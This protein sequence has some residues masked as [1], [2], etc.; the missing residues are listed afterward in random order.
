[1]D[2]TNIIIVCIIT[3]N[4]LI[5]W[6]IMSSSLVIGAGP[7]ADPLVVCLRGIRAIFPSLRPG[8]GRVEWNGGIMEGTCV[9]WQGGV[10]K[11][12]SYQVKYNYTQLL[13]PA[14]V[15]SCSAPLLGWGATGR[16]IR[17]QGTSFY[18]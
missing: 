17:E 4:R 14:T 13:I 1:M 2:V 15:F 6:S 5:V 18:R 7:L 3:L 11:L 12:I 10:C 16:S 8:E 9:H